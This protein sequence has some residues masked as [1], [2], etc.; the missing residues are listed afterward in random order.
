M[1]IAKVESKQFY[2]SGFPKEVQRSK[3]NLKL[4]ERLKA[5]RNRKGLSAA[6]VVRALKKRGVVIGHSTLQGYE[7]KEDS[8]NH[9]Y[10]SLPVL[11]ELADFY[12]CSLDYIFGTSERFKPYALGKEVDLLDVVESRNAISYNGVTLTKKQRQLVSDQLNL[13]LGEIAKA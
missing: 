2:E 12:G 1:Q 5:A 13:I 3:H 8:L 7:A 6:G 11:M 9:R 10:P 4:N